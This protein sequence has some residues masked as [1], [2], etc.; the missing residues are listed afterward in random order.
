MDDEINMEDLEGLLEDLSMS[1]Q[2]EDI[3]EC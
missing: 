1:D 3:E 2:E